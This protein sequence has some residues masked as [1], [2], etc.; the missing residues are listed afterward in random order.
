MPGEIR[1]L[2]QRVDPRGRV[3]EILRREHVPLTTFGQ[4]YVFT[5]VPGAVKGNHYHQ[6]KAEWFCVLAGDGELTLYDLES[7]YAE[8]L[9]M[10]AGEPAVVKIPPG[11]AHRMTNTGESELVVLAYITEP[12]DP[13]DPDTFPYMGPWSK[14]QQ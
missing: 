14:G 3:F 5:A 4:I 2:E 8:T 7:G 10:K 11:V 12:F 6:R 1:R 9:V 13:G